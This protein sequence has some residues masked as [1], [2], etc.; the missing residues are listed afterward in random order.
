[1]KRFYSSRSKNVNKFHTKDIVLKL[2]LNEYNLRT[3]IFRFFN[4]SN[5]KSKYIYVLVKI[6]YQEVF[7]YKTMFYNQIFVYTIVVI[8]IIFSYFIK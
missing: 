7:E 5:F 4:D 2:N 6:R 8:L 1:M 3:C